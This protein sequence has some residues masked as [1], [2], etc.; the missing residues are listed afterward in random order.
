MKAQK[1]LLLA[2][3][4]VFLTASVYPSQVS[5]DALGNQLY[6]PITFNNFRST[7]NKIVYASGY[8]ASN[9][10]FAIYV[11]NSD[12]SGKTNIASST[13][14]S[15]TQ[16]HWSPDGSKIA[17]S[18]LIRTSNDV[19]N[20]I[21]VMNADGSG[22]KAITPDT[23][24][25]FGETWSPDGAKLA[26]S[27]DLDDPGETTPN[28]IYVMNS[29]GSGSSTNLTRTTN[30][31]DHAPAWSPDGT[32]IAYAVCPLTAVTCQIY[33]MSSTGGGAINVS[34]SAH[35][36]Y[37][38]Q[39]SPDGEKIV[40]ERNLGDYTNTNYQVF[41]MNADGSGQTQLT[42]T[43]TEAYAPSWS[44]DGSKIVFNAYS[45][46][47]YDDIFVMNSNGTGQTNITN[48]WS[49]YASIQPDWR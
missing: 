41:I 27:S 23:A 5:A 42:S 34:N 43:L 4:L 14:A 44:P 10:R 46:N 29:D 36:D 20:Q 37:A 16:P 45:G 1:V 35:D 18:Q 12:G 15:F 40:F 2:L 3:V 32:K 38:P 24:H 6:L 47:N 39:W 7:L 21:M 13:T 31:S 25:S 28:D 17:F 49:S 33:V 48:T 19:I 11:M 26:F 8:S 30:A 22:Q 9:T